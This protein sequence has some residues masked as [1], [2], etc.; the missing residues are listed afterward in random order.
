M[1]NEERKFILWLKQ[2]QILEHKLM[3]WGG[4]RLEY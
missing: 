2:I 3:A 1:F 4:G